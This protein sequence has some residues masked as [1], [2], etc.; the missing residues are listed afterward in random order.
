MVQLGLEN[1]PMPAA[2]SVEMESAELAGVVVELHP[3]GAVDLVAWSYGGFLTLD[4][5]SRP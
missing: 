1:R 4:Y 3:I 5:C 2:Y